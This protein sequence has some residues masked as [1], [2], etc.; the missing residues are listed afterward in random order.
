MLTF[1]FSLALNLANISAP[2][3][4]PACETYA[5]RLDGI[6]VT[7]CNGRAVRYEDASG[8]VSEVA[9]K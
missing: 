9:S 5:A 3:A 8:N 6:K 2:V 4:A 7:V 1:L